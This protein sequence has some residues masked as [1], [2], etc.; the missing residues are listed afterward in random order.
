M[1]KPTAEEFV[2]ALRRVEED[3]DLEPMAALY[4][5][6][7]A[8]QTPT[9]H[10]RDVGPAGARRFWGAYRH[11]FLSIQSRFRG[12][13]ESDA[14]IMLEWTSVCRTA[15]GVETSYDGVSVVETRDGRI[16]RF[17][18]YFDPSQLTAHPALETSMRATGNA[19][20]ADGGSGPASATPRAN[21]PGG[22]E[23]PRAS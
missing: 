17:A 1:A 15:A 19:P 8:L 22:G 12:V 3:G 23:R 21:R 6:D 11:S 7:A 13:L 5:D 20:M 18:A 9:E 10:E 14:R 4:A 16:V 2:T